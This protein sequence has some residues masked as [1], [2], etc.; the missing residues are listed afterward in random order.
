MQAKTRKVVH[1]IKRLQFMAVVL[2]VLLL[3]S[4]FTGCSNNGLGTFQNEPTSTVGKQTE[5]NN[6]IDGPVTNMAQL[7]GTLWKGLDDDPRAIDV[8]YWRT[9]GGFDGKDF[10]TLPTWA[11]DIDDIDMVA[12]VTYNFTDSTMEWTRRE[13]LTFHGSG[14]TNHWAEIS[15]WTREGFAL[16]DATEPILIWNGAGTN[17]IDDSQIAEMGWVLSKGG[18]TLDMYGLILERQ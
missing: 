17:E 9:D 1:K 2:V 18:K 4:A 11:S 8:Y 5:A 14:V 15:G 6:N 7:A 12:W 13:E 16:E 3:T 10:Q